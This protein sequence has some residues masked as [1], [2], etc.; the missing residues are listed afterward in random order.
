MEA[1]E[2]GVGQELKLGEGRRK[3]IG[4]ST[5]KGFAFTSRKVLRV[6]AQV[7]AVK[8]TWQSPCTSAL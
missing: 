6:C 7:P 5:E 8:T 3:R 1:A 2:F 4:G